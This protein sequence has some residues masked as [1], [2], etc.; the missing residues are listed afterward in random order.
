MR[1]SNQQY[2]IIW[3]MDGVLVNTGEYHY[4]AWKKTF[5]ELDI[6]F[7]KEQFRGTFGMN[8]AGI[9]EAICR[10]KLPPDQEKSI[11]QQKEKLFRQAI[12]GKAKLLHG[13]KGAL[14]SFSEWNLKQA[15]ASSAP[16][17][18]IQVLV[19]ELKI[20]KYFDATVSGYDIPGKPD[21][22]VF[23]KA[24]RQLNVLPE[25]CVVIEDAVAGVEGAKN[26]GM[27]CIAVTTTNTTEALSKADLIFDTLEG[28]KP[29]ILIAL[30]EKPIAPR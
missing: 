27:K 9:L 19:N 16:P 24:A 18:N 21:P 10:Q 14:K 25:N 15:I 4:Q 5:D 13:V 26:A 20:G 2:A 22:M 8:N 1:A 11:S 28:L 12:K 3:D 30:F 29:S 23:L 6:S 7:S 17:E